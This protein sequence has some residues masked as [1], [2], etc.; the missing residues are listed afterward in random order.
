MHRAEPLK[1]LNQY[2]VAIQVG[3]EGLRR[4]VV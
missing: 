2:A 3:V 1:G 4:V